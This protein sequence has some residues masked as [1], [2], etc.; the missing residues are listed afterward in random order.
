MVKDPLLLFS[1][2]DQ[3]QNPLVLVQ[4]Q[5][6]EHGGDDVGRRDGE[7]ASLTDLTD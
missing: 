3:L 1:S 6:R 4:S 7:I 5:G 2:L